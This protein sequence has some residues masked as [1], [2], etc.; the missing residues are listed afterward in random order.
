MKAI[1]QMLRKLNDAL[2]KDGTINL[3][4]SPYAGFAAASIFF[5]A[6][7]AYEFSY[8]LFS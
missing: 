2:E 5:V 3:L 8:W 1:K 7:L 4:R 6:V